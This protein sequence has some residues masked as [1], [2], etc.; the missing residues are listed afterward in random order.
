[1]A[2][3]F[4]VGHGTLSQSQF[5]DVLDAAGVRRL[6]DVRRFPGSRRH[7]QF[8]RGEMAAWLP[9]RDVQ[10]R[11]DERLGGRREAADESPHVGL[12]HG[13]FRAYADHM[14]S[15]DFR[16]AVR[17]LLQEVETAA[18]AVMCAESVWWRCHRRLLA[19]AVT[20][21]HDQDVVHLFHDGRL[22]AHVP[23]DAARVVTAA[24]GADRL[25]Y[26]V[27]ANLALP[28]A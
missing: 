21:L 24:D 5:G 26:D 3:L 12:R 25:R 6:V 11:W 9:E 23:T 1:M 16:Y 22:A 8:N 4:T 14:T 15:D 10:Y 27:G 28:E 19:D 17:D 2:R 7:P 20:L 18:T 13:Q